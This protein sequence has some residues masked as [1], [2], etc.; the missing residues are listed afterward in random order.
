[1][2][3]CAIC[4]SENLVG[5]CR[6]DEVAEEDCQTGAVRPRG[7]AIAVAP[8]GRGDC[9]AP[10]V[11]GSKRSEPS[12]MGALRLPAVDSCHPTGYTRM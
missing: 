11:N 9:G 2:P 3:A 8:K 6:T 12:A 10:L 5:K 7:V 4:D 1:M